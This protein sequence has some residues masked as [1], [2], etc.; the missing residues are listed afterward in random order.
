MTDTATKPAEQATSKP[1]KSRKANVGSDAT[2]GSRVKLWQ[3]GFYAF[4]IGA[5]IIVVGATVNS[6]LKGNVPRAGFAVSFFMIGITWS[7]L[8]AN[9][10]KKSDIDGVRVTDEEPELQAFVRSVAEEIGV[11][12]PK[13]IVLGVK[14]GIDMRELTR[15]FGRTVDRS[16]L[17]IGLPFLSTMTKREL[18]ALLAHMLAHNADGDV[19]EG[20][21]AIRSLR[22]GRKLIAA[23]RDGF[24]NGVY[25]SYARKMFRSV[26]G[27][28][29]AQEEQADRLAARA[30]GTD[31]L[32]SALAQ[33]D[34]TVVAF[35]QMLRHYVVPA[36]QNEMHPRD[37]YEGFTKVYESSARAESRTEALQQR[38]AKE[39]NEFDLHQTPQERMLRVQSWPHE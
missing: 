28:A 35:D 26:G 3:I 24:V 7:L 9:N 27:V 36:M 34:D 33:V 25:G 4:A 8:R 39:R 20:A 13:D 5:C 37:L 23:E 21:A 10:D 15:H 22:E 11:E 31:A 18:A 2:K 12:P 6:L 38:L 32:L 19:A 29:V 14:A 16:A 1:A 17:I 30:Y